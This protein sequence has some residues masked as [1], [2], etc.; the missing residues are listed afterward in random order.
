M[1]IFASYVCPAE[2]ARALDDVRLSKML[3]ET[4]QI[5]STVLRQKGIETPYR[6]THEHH[7]VVKWVG[8]ADANFNWTAQH[9]MQLSREFEFRRERE[10]LS[11]RIYRPLVQ[12]RADVFLAQLPASFCNCARRADLGIDFTW[13]ENTHEAY[14]RYLAARWSRDRLPPTWHKRQ[15]PLFFRQLQAEGVS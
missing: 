8:A 2:S 5:L 6:S 15:P 14:R 10:H 12:A 13:M 1:N 7:P 9:F 11:T 3:L 4:A